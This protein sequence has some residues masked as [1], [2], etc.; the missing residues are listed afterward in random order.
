MARRSG[1]DGAGRFRQ[2]KLLGQHFL[3]SRTVL[4]KIVAAANLTPTDTVLEIGP[5]RGILTFA[6]AE[7]AGKVIAVEKDP[8]LAGLL[9]RELE[10]RGIKNVTIIRGDILKLFPDQ[11]RLPHYYRVVA[12]IPF[13]LTSR[14]IRRLLES[15]E[16]P[17]DILLTVQKEVAERIVAKPPRMNLLAL[18]VQAYCRPRILFRIPASAFNPRPKVESAAIALADISTDFFTKHNIPEAAFFSLLRAAFSQK[19]KTIANS[20]ARALG[21]KKQGIAVLRRAG[22]PPAA[23]PET[24]TL[25]DWARLLRS[26]PPSLP[27]SAD[28]GGGVPDERL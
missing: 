21:D 18:A 3:V 7:R 25:E 24:L 4:A 27:D 1:R 5:G 9:E 23:R 15:A 11:L 22:V 6:L 8:R 28:A 16:R 13:Y 26:A 17:Q 2:E 14:L 12:N 19:R 10:S 20:L